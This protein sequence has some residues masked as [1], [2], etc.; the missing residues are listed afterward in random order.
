MFIATLL[1]IIPNQITQMNK[2][3]V[4]Y[5]FREIL[6][7]KK[8]N[9]LLIHTTIWMNFQDISRAKDALSH[10]QG[11]P[12]QAKCKSRPEVSWSRE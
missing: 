4:A 9:K 11:T 12:G 2:Q 10:P 1:I 7:S 6:L 5:P 8:K 3:I